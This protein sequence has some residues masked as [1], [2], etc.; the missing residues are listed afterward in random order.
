MS[1][2]EPLSPVVEDEVAEAVTD[3]KAAVTLGLYISAARCI[4]TY[5]IAP[6]LGAVGIVFGPLGLLLQIFGGV[7]ATIGAR[8]L[9]LL[10]HRLWIPYAL[11]AVAIDALAVFAL[12]ELIR[13]WG[14]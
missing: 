13:D 12:Y 9:W 8:R 6:A 10:K 5:M 7:M 2:E 1:S 14:S 11:L 3:A 4:F